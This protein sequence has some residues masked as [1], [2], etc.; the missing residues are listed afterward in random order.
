MLNRDRVL[1]AIEGLARQVGRVA[2]ALEYPLLNRFSS[3]TAPAPCSA[4]GCR[5]IPIADTSCPACAQDRKDSN[6]G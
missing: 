5:L 2:W 4:C 1:S 3:A 6:H